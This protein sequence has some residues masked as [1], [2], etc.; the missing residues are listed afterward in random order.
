MDKQKSDDE[1]KLEIPEWLPQSVLS[2]VTT[3]EAAVLW[4]FSERVLL[5]DLEHQPKH[6]NG[7]VAVNLKQFTNCLNEFLGVYDNA[8]CC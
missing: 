6:G 7:I 8:R 4:F 2:W 1:V 3:K 5:P